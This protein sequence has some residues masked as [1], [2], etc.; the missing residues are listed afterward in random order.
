MSRRAVIFVVR[1]TSAAAD[2]GVVSISQIIKRLSRHRAIIVTDK[3][4]EQFDRWRRSGIEVHVLPQ[5]ASHGVFRAPLRV[6][7]SYLQYAKT[8][9]RLIA[10]S[11]ARIVHANDSSA[12]QLSLWP[13]RKSGA[14]ILLNMRDTLDPD[15]RAPG[16]RYRFLFSAADHV[17]YLSHDMANRWEA[18]ASNAKR[19]CS[20]TYSVV[21]LDAFKP[22]DAPATNS[23]IVL[24]SGIIRPKKGQLDF[25]RHVAPALA[26]RGISTWLMGDFDP[27]RDAYM[28][29][30]A[31]AASPLGK[32]VKFLGYRTDVARLLA[33]STVVA[34]ASRYEGLV[35]AMIEAMGSGRPVVSFDV[36][37]ARELLEAESGGAGVVVPSGDY[38]SMV[39][40]IVAYCSDADRAAQA[41][42][43]GFKTAQRLFAPEEVA[44]RYES[45][46]DALEA[47]A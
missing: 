25:I 40:A 14:K 19:S 42:S 21:D 36:C 34:V 5:A 45:T 38:K 11:G 9:S 37:S 6:G 1:Q 3:R 43:L 31:E 41:G 44:E 10:S 35:R 17:F 28:A 8:L 12:F 46:Y 18:I 27:A 24:L 39:E 13:A 30:C 22:S 29:A 4:S 2:G 26:A 32:Y 7:Q 15:R 47:D 33:K 16:A 20:V 23:P